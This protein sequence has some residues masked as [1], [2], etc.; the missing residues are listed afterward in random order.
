M[1][2]GSV[3]A[4]GTVGTVRTRPSNREAP[5]AG[6][7]GSTAGL[8]PSRK[9]TEQPVMTQQ[10]QN[11]LCGVSVGRPLNKQQ[12]TLGR[13]LFPGLTQDNDTECRPQQQNQTKPRV[14][15]EVRRNGP[16][17]APTLRKPGRWMFQ[18]KTL[19]QLFKVY[20]KN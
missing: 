5:S 9:Q 4:V 18:T 19:N 10:P 16:R 7:Q 2:A 1:Q 6:T 13:E 15:K 11:R 8:W 17:L 20:S 12:Q 14:C 3:G